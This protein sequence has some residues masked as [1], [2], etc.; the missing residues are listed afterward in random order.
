MTTANSF[1]YFCGTESL[2]KIDYNL[3][4]SI[5]DLL[6]NSTCCKTRSISINDIIAAPEQDSWLTDFSI[7]RKPAGASFIIFTVDS[8]SWGPLMAELPLENLP[9]DEGSSSPV[10]Q[11]LSVQSDFQK[12][13]ISIKAVTVRMGFDLFLETTLLR[14]ATLVWNRRHNN[15]SNFKLANFKISNTLRSCPN[16]SSSRKSQPCQSHHN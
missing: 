5:L 2:T 14:N 7:R 16:C 12:S 1:L 4:D 3:Y 11:K 10:P 15:G 8:C 6:K 9:H 13:A